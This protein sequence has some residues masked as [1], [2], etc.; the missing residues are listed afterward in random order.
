VAHACNPRTQELEAGRSE[1]I[2]SHPLLLEASL[3][4]ME[5]DVKTESKHNKEKIHA[6]YGH[7]EGH[8]KDL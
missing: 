5:P 7:G 1:E 3:G 6:S 4:Y 2:Q 8:I